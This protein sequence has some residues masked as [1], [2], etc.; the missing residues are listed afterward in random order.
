MVCMLSPLLSVRLVMCPAGLRTAV[1]MVHN[2]VVMNGVQAGVVNNDI[3][4]VAIEDITVTV[5]GDIGAV[6]VIVNH[7][8][9]KIW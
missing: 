2:V 3:A 6:V 1:T 4:V 5:T 8:K 7:V 9:K